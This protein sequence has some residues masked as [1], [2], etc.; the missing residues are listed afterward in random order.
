MNRGLICLN[1]SELG[2]YNIQ[3]YDLL[4]NC[5]LLLLIFTAKYFEITTTSSTNIY[6]TFIANYLPMILFC[7]MTYCFIPNTNVNDILPE[8]ILLPR[9]DWRWA[10]NIL[11]LK[12]LTYAKRTRPCVVSHTPATPTLCYILQSNIRPVIYYFTST[13]PWNGG[14]FRFS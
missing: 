14:Q 13:Y 8:K 2:W 4:Y 11:Y 3:Q 7:L 9:W 6:W 5:K 12:T 1:W 10:V